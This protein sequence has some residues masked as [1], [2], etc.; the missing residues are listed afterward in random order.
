MF[1]ATYERGFLGGYGDRIVGLI[2]VYV[3]ADIF[4]R[5]FKLVWTK[6]PIH[7]HVDI[8]EW[9]T[10]GLQMPPYVPTI[11]LLSH[12]PHDIQRKL[13]TEPLNRIFPYEVTK[14]ILNQ[15]LVHHFYKNP[16]HIHKIPYTDRMMAAYRD[17]YTRIMPPTPSTLQTIQALTGGRRDFVG[18]QVRGGDIYMNP[19]ESHKVLDAA[20]LPTLFQRIAE[21]LAA[22]TNT[23]PIF[24]TSDMGNQAY[25]CAKAVWGAR[26]QYNADPVQHMDWKG[27]AEDATASW[28]VYVD[29]YILANCT[30]RLYI[31]K[32]S[33]Y[34][35]VAA[36]A[37]PHDDIWDLETC[38]GL[39]KSELFSKHTQIGGK[40]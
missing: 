38:R 26:V 29:N 10:E 18:I 7:R 30:T 31:T 39:V 17:L 15:E 3:L 1:I 6:E 12:E 4:R 19:T 13:R 5:P 21:H 9:S 25:D 16:H 32:A 22:E 28:K 36:L 27:G 14:F 34:G 20:T 11:L 2:S 33:N 35:R 40:N 23:C 24:L 37:A 8:R